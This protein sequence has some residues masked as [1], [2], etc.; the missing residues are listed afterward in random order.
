MYSKIRK[1]HIF[2]MELNCVKLYIYKNF[3][4]FIIIYSYN[5][6]LFNFKL[7]YVNILP[8][9]QIVLYFF[10]V[11]YDRWR[12][13]QS[14]KMAEN[15]FFYADVSS[16]KFFTFKHEWM[17]YILENDN[18]LKKKK[19]KTKITLLRIVINWTYL[20][21]QNTKTWRTYMLYYL[22]QRRPVISNVFLK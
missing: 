3:V 1:I 17:P 4:T 22:A 10:W 21:R 20:L 14:N 8:K 6:L 7:L 2:Y 11:V 13:F 5:L 9:K 18:V 19:K 16:I 15:W 12:D